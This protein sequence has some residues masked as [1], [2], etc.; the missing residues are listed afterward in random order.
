MATKSIDRRGFLTAASLLSVGSVGVRPVRAAGEPDPPPNIVWLIAD[1]VSPQEFG[2]YGHPTIRTPHIDRLAREG[3]RFSRAYVTTSS[4][5]PSRASLFTGKYPHST[6]AENLHDPLPEDQ[7]VL[8]EL[9]AQRGYYSG[10]VGKFHMGSATSKKFD[11]VLKRVEDWRP[12]LDERPAGRPFFLSVGFHDAHR[13]FERGC[14]DPPHAPA[15]VTVP[16]YLPDTPEVREDLAAFYDE[17]SRM[18]EVVGA[19]TQ[20]LESEGIL[21]NTLIVFLGD[22]GMPFPRAKTTLYESGIQ[23]PLIVHW[24]RAFEA[25]R[26]DCGLTSLVDLAPTMLDAGGVAVPDAMQGRSLIQRLRNPGRPGRRYVFAEKNW[27]DMDDH[28]GA[29]TDGRYK[30]IRNAYPDRPLP[31]ATDCINSPTFKTMK[32]MRDAGTLSDEAMLLFRSRRAVE[33]LY[34]LEYDAMEF[35]SLAGDPAYGRVLERLRKA[36]DRWVEETQDVSPSEALPDEFDPETGK[37]IHPPHQ[38]K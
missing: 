30:Y 12:F 38:R 31:T 28:S 6:G 16:P 1:D 35:H 18:D 24:P 15:D 22:N 36:L 29:V 25:G 11:R 5:S 34:D 7:A 9:L 33:E 21:E 8:S 23:T 2:C 13:P 17:I 19:L 20:A 3:A 37:R 4:C 10:S 27:H 32:A 26:V 14:V